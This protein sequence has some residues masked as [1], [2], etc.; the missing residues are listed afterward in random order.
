MQEAQAAL[1]RF[2][3][4]SEREVTEFNRYCESLMSDTTAKL[5]KEENKS[6]KLSPHFLATLGSL[7]QAD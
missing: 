4:H 6:K 7:L 3:A 2:Q 5:T 1:Q